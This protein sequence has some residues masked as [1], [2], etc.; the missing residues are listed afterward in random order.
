[1]NYINKQVLV[2]AT[3]AGVFFGTLLEKEGDEVVLKNCRRIWY[4]AGAASINQLAA[5]G[6]C[7]PNDCK[8]TVSV[9]DICILGVIEIIPCTQK[10]IES[11]TS[12]PTWKA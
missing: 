11:I 5:D 10:A 4:W 2:R 7:R 8:F 3:N 9:D 6:T 1:M 12:V